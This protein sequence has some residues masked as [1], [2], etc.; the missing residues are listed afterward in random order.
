[1]LVCHISCSFRVNFEQMKVERNLTNGTNITYP[2][3][4]PY[5][6][7]EQYWFSVMTDDNCLNVYVGLIVIVAPLMIIRGI[8][9]FKSCV[10]A[11]IN[12]HNNMFS[13]IVYAPMR[14][15]HLNPSGRILNRFSKDV[16]QVDELLPQT[17]S[18][19][20]QVILIHK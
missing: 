4:S 3:D 5:S 6:S 20:I 2:E 19:T 8:M 17:L 11:S 18:T 9:F 12:L 14:F 10:Q 7:M 1:M 13:K 16:N 15:F